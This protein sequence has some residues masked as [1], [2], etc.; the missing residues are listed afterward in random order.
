MDLKKFWESSRSTIVSAVIAI[1]VIAG[2]FVIFNVLPEEESTNEK[3][4]Q[5]QEQEKENE[6]KKDTAEEEQDK[7]EL[8]AEYTVKQGDNLWEISKVHYGT[9]KKWAAI[10]SVNKISTPDQIAVG[11]KLNIPETRDYKVKSGDTLWDIAERSY[12]SGFEWT[13]IRDANPS[14]T[15]TLPNGNNL[16]MVGQVLVI[17]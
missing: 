9:G 8:P 13:K 17:P 4:E 15:G 10:A 7:K 2:L 3:E 11:S 1:V 14:M 5:K 16:I 12:G 6:E